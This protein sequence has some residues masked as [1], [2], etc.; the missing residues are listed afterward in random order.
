MLNTFCTVSKYC[1]TC[2]IGTSDYTVQTG[3][4]VISEDSLMQCVS[5]PIRS[6]ST[7]E[8]EECFTFGVTARSTVT[9]LTVE[10]S[11]TEICITDTYCEWTL[12][13]TSYVCI[14]SKLVLCTSW[15]VLHY[16]EQVHQCVNACP[17]I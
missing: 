6:D 12:I 4:L 13:K 2:S 7:T 3:N 16:C 9:G 1:F 10:P 17:N 11:E 15:R 14:H 5:I 8:S